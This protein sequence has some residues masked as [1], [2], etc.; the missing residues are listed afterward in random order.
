MIKTKHT[1]SDLI[2][3]S[4]REPKEAL[5]SLYIY[6]NLFLDVIFSISTRSRHVSAQRCD[7]SICPDVFKISFNHD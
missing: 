1:K 6:T 7:F 2:L 5:K 4:D 3:I